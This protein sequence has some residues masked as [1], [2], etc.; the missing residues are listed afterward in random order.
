[1]NIPIILTGIALIF[2]S[3]LMFSES[4]IISAISLIIGLFLLFMELVNSLRIPD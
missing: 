4:R 2:F 1:M 3:K